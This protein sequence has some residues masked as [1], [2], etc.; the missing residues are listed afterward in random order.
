M[1]YP[2][3]FFTRSRQNS[4]KKDPGNSITFVDVRSVI[5]I[6]MKGQGSTA[7]KLA[8][9]ANLEQPSVH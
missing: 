8:K 9:L 5:V 4:A 1:S 6:A 2:C 3:K 7:A